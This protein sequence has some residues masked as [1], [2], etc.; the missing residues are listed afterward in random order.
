MQ[1][2]REAL[3]KV[4]KNVGD[5]KPQLSEDVGTKVGHGLLANLELHT[6]TKLTFNPAEN[7]KKLQKV[8][9]V[10]S[11][12]ALVGQESKTPVEMA[13]PAAA[14][15]LPLRKASRNKIRESAYVTLRMALRIQFS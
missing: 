12:A 4:N 6:W 9:A 3:A 2:S 15:R 13:L 8:L 11:K 10:A 7:G 1:T 5:K 14:N